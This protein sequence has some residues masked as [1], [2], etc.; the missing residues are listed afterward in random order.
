MFTNIDLI[1]DYFT[2]AIF[3]LFSCRKV[4]KYDIE[5]SLLTRQLEQS[6]I[7]ELQF[8]FIFH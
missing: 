2:V 3:A 6:W 8:V 5:V 4:K 1:T 7:L